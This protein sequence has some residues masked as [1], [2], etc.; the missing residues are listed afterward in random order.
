MAAHKMQNSYIGLKDIIEIR[1][2]FFNYIVSNLLHLFY[3]L[4]RQ[5]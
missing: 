1:I 5:V 4:K 3:I 2:L